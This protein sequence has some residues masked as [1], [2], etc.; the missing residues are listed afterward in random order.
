MIAGHHASM[1]FLEIA[2][3]RTV[4]CVSTPR[5]SITSSMLFLLFSYSIWYLL[6][7]KWMGVALVIQHIVKLMPTKNTKVMQYYRYRSNTQHAVAT[8]QSASVIKVSEWMHS[9]AFKRKLHSNNFIPKNNF[10]ILLKS[11]IDYK[12]V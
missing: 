4:V 12:A 7:I 3:V 11:F 6:L 5:A 8:R 9:N 1:Q 2:L 10:L